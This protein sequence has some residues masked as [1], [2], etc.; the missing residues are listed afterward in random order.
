MN[1]K[2]FLSHIQSI[3][4]RTGFS[5]TGEDGCVL[6]EIVVSTDQFIENTHFT[7]K[8]MSPEQIGFK[9][10]VQALSDL[11][12]MASPPRGIL[13]SA[14]WSTAADGKILGLFSGIEQACLEYKIPLLGGDI[15]RTTGPTYLDFTV[16]GANQ[17]V[18][19]KAGAQPGDLIAVTGPLGS[20]QGG[21]YCLNKDQNFPRLIQAFQRPQAHIATACELN[22]QGVITSLTDISDSLA[23]SLHDFLAHSKF[24]S[25]IQW[26]DLPI[27][28]EL[29]QLCKIQNLDLHE[30]VLHG[31]E[32]Y[33][34]LMTLR[35]DTSEKL[36][37]D[38]RLTLIGKTISR[39]EIAC[40][41]AGQ[42]RNITEVGW[43]PFLL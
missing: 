20:A 42:I 5:Q 17:K 16:I 27:D 2:D 12:A 10:V 9:G 33:Q 1:E 30:F 39:A 7:W 43:D 28:E 8:Q 19:T 13:C 29:R 34:L 23:K 40:V 32:D 26:Q 36:I 38:H 4:Q 18:P 24:G 22:R 41:E 21:F 3:S 31:G 15:S 11:A 6:G 25:E 14:A 37:S 35:P